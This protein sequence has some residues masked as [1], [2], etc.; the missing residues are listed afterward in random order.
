MSSKRIK[1]MCKLIPQVTEEIYEFDAINIEDIIELSLVMLESLKGT[2][3]DTG[4][5]L[6]DIMEEL[7]SIISGS[8]APFIY[9]AS[10]Q[11]KQNEEIVAAIMISYYE[12]HP[13][14]S[15]IF[16]KKQYYNLGMAEALM[17]HSINALLKMDYEEANLYVDPRNT[18]A[19][20]LYKKIG[21]K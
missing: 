4:E 20:T 11:I 9:D 14:I 12:G 10:Y 21:F 19:I 15:E 2:C 17:R 7:D 13:L 16:T 1:M 18:A 3:E 6:E 8:F 5:T